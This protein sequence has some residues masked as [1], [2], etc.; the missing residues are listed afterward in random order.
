MASTTKRHRV[1]VVEDE[2]LIAQDVAQRL[3]SLGIE[4][5]ATVGTAAE[6]I[7][8]APRADLV[9]MDIGLDGP[10]DGIQ[11]AAEIH[12]RFRLPTVFLTSKADRSTIDRA[13]LAK[14]FGYLIK[15][16]A[17]G[18]LLA[19]IE[20]AIHRHRIELR[21]E[22]SETWL[23]A[24]LASVT[25]AIVVTDALGQIRFLNPAAESL[26]GWKQRQ[27][28]GLPAEKILRLK[29]ESGSG[30]DPLTLA[31]LRDG[32]VPLHPD[33]RCIARNAREVEVEGSVAPLKTGGASIG[34]V[35]SLRDMTARRWEERHL[36]Q[37]HRIEAASRLAASVASDYS[38]LIATI[39]NQSEQLLRQFPEYSS[40]RGAVEEIQEAA[41]LADSITKRLLSIGERQVMQPASLSLNALLRR[42]SRLIEATAG[43]GIRVTA[44]L[45]HGPNKI[46]A[47]QTLIEQV[48][49]NLVMHSCAAMTEGGELRIETAN[50]E[51]QG[52]PSAKQ[53]YVCL[54]VT[55]SGATPDCQGIFEASASSDQDMALPAV[56]TIVTEH[57]GFVSA[58]RGPNG[59]CRFEVLLPRSIESAAA[60]TAGDAPAVLFIDER[61]AVRAELHNFFEAAGYNLIEAADTN[62]ARALAE[63]HE[64]PLDLLVCDG[65]QADA[66]LPEIRRWHPRI[67]LLRIT[68]HR[69]AAPDEIQRPF[70][71]MALRDCVVSRINSSRAATSAS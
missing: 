1:L 58:E 41:T 51:I 31:L 66:I 18:A 49:M 32:P 56:H 57:D 26:A 44:E 53:N 59:G 42:M 48:I 6:A 40:A 43:A 23:R 19:A 60:L 61:E 22:E 20:I 7:E 15:P 65:R 64:G 29:S 24:V 47:D 71:Q 68:D 46:H 10:T 67:E 11:A 52:V 63:V 9:L 8:N 38:S 21:L 35:V 25:E 28:E 45:R 62:E 5:V 34:A 12:Q 54:S 36:R 69:S 3:E 17:T 13:K 33:S 27:A 30:S 70:T 39:R 14:P 2:D 50:I 4:V 55:H 37:A 16:V